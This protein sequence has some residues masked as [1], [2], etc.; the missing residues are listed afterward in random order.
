MH[1]FSQDTVVSVGLSQSC[2]RHSLPCIVGYFPGYL[3]D[4]HGQPDQRRHRQA[5]EESQAMVLVP[6]GG[7]GLRQVSWIQR[8]KAGCQAAAKRAW[9]LLRDPQEKR[10]LP[11]PALSKFPT[12]REG[13]GSEEE[14]LDVR[15]KFTGLPF[16][17]TGDRPTG[18]AILLTRGS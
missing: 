3:G 2:P 5:L 10:V 6:K 1:A 15:P 16:R 17:P 18:E 12:P 4:W 8:T 11:K 9:V 7:L 13:S 14:I